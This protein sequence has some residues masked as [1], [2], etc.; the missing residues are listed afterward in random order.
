VGTPYYM[1]ELHSF[2]RQ[3]RPIPAVLLR[4][5]Q[6]WLRD[7]RGVSAVEFA[8]VAPLLISLL[9]GVIQ[10][11][12]IFLV[13][14]RMND[15]ARDTARRLAVGDIGT[16]SDGES[17]ARAQLSDW[18]AA[19]HV[20]AALPRAPDRDIAVTITVPMMDAA[21]LNFVSVGLDG[22]MRSEIHMMKE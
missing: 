11:G 21:I 15:T 12:S 8:L 5:G 20:V 18:P 13:Q 14:M 19:F 4:R 2:I 17:F 16:E 22:D 3:C 10:Y 7:E 9:L 1:S 6:A